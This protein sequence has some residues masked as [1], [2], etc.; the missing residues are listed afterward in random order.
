MFDPS[1]LCSAKAVR[2]LK[3]NKNRDKHR[4]PRNIVLLLA[5]IKSRP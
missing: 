3:H 1:L 5:F 4:I 2:E